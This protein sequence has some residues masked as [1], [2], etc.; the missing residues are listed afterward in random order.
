MRRFPKRFS[1]GI[2]EEMWSQLLELAHRHQRSTEWMAR[3]LIA[4]GLRS[5]ES[6]K[7]A[8]VNHRDRGDS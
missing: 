7:P 1:V 3:K 2:T 4:D 5:R 8:D 6:L